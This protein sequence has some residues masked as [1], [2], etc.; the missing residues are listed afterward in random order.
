MQFKIKL[1]AITLLWLMAPHFIYAFSGN[2]LEGHVTDEQGQPLI[3]AVVRLPDLKSGA[4]TDTAGYYRIT[5]L[6]KGKYLVEVHLLSY[7]T[8]TMPVE[9]SGT[10][11]ASFQL[12]ESVI[13][14]NEVVITGTSLATEERKS[15][16]P[17]Q[18]LSMKEMR[19]NA[20]A[21]VID[22]ISRMPGVSQ[23]T[24]GPA[25]SKP[26][27]RGLSYNRI[28]TLNDGIRQEGQQWGDEHGIEIDDYN[29]SRIEVLKGPASLA[30]GSDA[31]AGV[32]NI[33]SDES[34]PEGKVQGN[35]AANYQTNDGLAA[36][37]ARVAGNIKGIS[38]NTYVTGKAAHDY[39]NRY[40]SY[41][42]DSR[43]QNLNYGASVAINKKWGS[44]RLSYTS[45]NQILGIPEGDRDS[46][47]G[48]FLRLTDNNGVSEN[49]IATDADG[50]SYQRETPSQ[51]IDHQKLV[52]NN[53]LYLNKGARFDV[54]LGYQQNKRR[55][56]EDVLRPDKPGLFLLL[57]TLNYDIRY[58]LPTWNNWQ[59]SMGINGMQQKNTNKGDE[60]LVPDYTLFDGGI[61]A[62]AKRDWNK[63]TLSG[64]LRYNYRTIKANS[65]H[66]DSSGVITAN[67]QPGGYQQ[68]SSFDR[69]FS[70]IVGSI[71]ASY[72]IAPRMSL[73][74]NIATGFRSP[75]IA[76]LSANGVHEGTIRYEYGNSTLK[77]EK[78]IEGD[79][80]LGWNSDHI[81]VN[82]SI[83]YNYIK[84]FIYVAKLAAVNGGDSI[85]VQ[86]DAQGYAAFNYKQTDAVL[87]GGELFIDLH[88][89]P[90]DWLHFEN[91]F[92]YVRGLSV[93]GT[94]STKYLPFIPPARWLIELRAQKR[95]L[96]KLIA[97]AYV[98]T[99]VDI[100]FAQNNVLSAYGTE[101][102]T[103]GYTLLNAGIGADIINRKQQIICSVNV[104]GQNLTNLAYQNHL[105]RLKYA[106][107]NYATGCSGIYSMGRNISVALNI[108]LNFK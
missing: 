15:V 96:G 66:L 60:Y 81:L 94:D 76:E 10:T 50:K 74:A 67:L 95:S 44:S 53:S 46:T 17:I 101:T 73:K 56:Y 83:F 51:R 41:V 105:S 71:G 23:V 47:T 57:Q 61:Y 18:S 107:V 13:E 88:P 29:V 91:T 99:G 87:Y 16:T 103:P 22:A 38:W 40:D 35:I 108:P 85:P 5:D 12:H 36:L 33:I 28:I 39:Q 27:I 49:I 48:R 9:V 104:S 92:S 90:L 42:S 26:V 3:G 24:T 6:P 52:W 54:T 98:K 7:A 2:T 63:W 86:N 21:N 25:V 32:V 69:N 20:S 70:N 1:L 55:E 8:V 43:F 72:A 84:D 14:R 78:S 4:V 80:G 68:F 79:L 102:P 64:G 59:I 31:L 75:N 30:Y 45:F 58:F 65:L 93:H 19:E 77:P 82:A 34:L 62:I 100:N 37:H 89:H 106:P 97:S 11:E